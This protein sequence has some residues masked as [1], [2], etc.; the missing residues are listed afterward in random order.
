MACQ[1]NSG[2]KSALIYAQ[3]YES[4][5]TFLKEKHCKG[6]LILNVYILLSVKV[7][8]YDVVFPVETFTMTIQHRSG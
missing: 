1:W 6:L 8:E 4:D 2:K 3:S 7:A 5:L